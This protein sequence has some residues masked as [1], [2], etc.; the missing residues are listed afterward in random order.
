MNSSPT[1]HPISIIFRN[2]VFVYQDAT[3]KYIKLSRLLV[4]KID[5]DNICSVASIESSYKSNERARVIAD[6]AKN[7]PCREF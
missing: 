6:N 2:F 1:P 3:G 5:H 7:M 4:V